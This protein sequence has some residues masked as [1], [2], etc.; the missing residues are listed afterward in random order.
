MC[1]STNVVRRM[2]LKSRMNAGNLRWQL[3]P[4]CIFLC[5]SNH[6]VGNDCAPG[7]MEKYRWHVVAICILPSIP[8]HRPGDRDFLVLVACSRYDLSLLGDFHRH[9]TVQVSIQAPIIQGPL[10]VRIDFWGTLYENLI[11][12]PPQ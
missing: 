4:T 8:N 12:E 1:S 6:P 10:I 2:R 7:R 5:I 11:K 3:V 9:K